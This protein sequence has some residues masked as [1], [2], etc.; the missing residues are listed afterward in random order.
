MAILVAN[1]GDRLEEIYHR[2]HDTKRVAYIAFLKANVHLLNKDLL[3]AGDKVVL[4]EYET[5]DPRVIQVKQ[6]E[7]LW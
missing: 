1:D 7:T 3:D 5:I 4:V 2:N 6:R